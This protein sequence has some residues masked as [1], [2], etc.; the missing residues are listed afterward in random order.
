MQVYWSLMPSLLAL[1]HTWAHTLTH[2]HL[3][4]PLIPPAARYLEEQLLMALAGRAGE[5]LM[6]GRDEL[7]SL[8]QHRLQLARQIVH[9]LLN[10]GFSEHPDFENIRA[11]GSAR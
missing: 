2:A 6:F 3:P 11:L 9:K 1:H 10:S 8:N 7:S 5:E 4:Q